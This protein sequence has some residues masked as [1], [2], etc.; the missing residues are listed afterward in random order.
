MGQDIVEAPA[1]IRG[2][3]GRVA[4]RRWPLVA[5]IAWVHAIEP[6]LEDR[7]AI[8]GRFLGGTWGG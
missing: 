4:E 6:C 7:Q 5:R 3:D 2:L 1:W 8:L